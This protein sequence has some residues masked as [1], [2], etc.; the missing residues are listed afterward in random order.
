MGI[1]MHHIICDGWSVAL[2]SYELSTIYN[3]LKK[4]PSLFLE[5]VTKITNLS[6]V[7]HIVPTPSA[8]TMAKNILSYSPSHFLLTLLSTYKSL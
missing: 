3:C 8:S 1:T 7:Q 2:F 6:E 5:E 4:E